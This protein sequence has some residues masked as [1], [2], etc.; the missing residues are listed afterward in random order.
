MIRLILLLS[1][2]IF[3]MNKTIFMLWLQG[4]ENAP[5][6]VTRCV[7]SWRYYNS[8]WNIILLDDNNLI[9][10]IKLDEYIDISKKQIEKCKIANI[11]RCILLCK[12]GGVWTDA[13]TFCNKPLNDWLPN[14]INE[15]F[16][17]FSK[18]TNGKM[19]SNWF[20]YAEKNNYII[21][22]WCNA[23]INFHVNNEMPYPYFIHHYLFGDLYNSD[24]KFKDIWDNVPKLS[25][26]GLGP[27]YLQEKG[28]FNQITDE[29]K[30]DIDNKITPLYKLTHKCNF[31]P[32]NKELNIYYL[33][34]TI[35]QFNIGYF[36][37]HTL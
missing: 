17:A 34:S 36:I 35:Q 30:E 12:Y 21:D 18:P 1:F 6:I 22:K 37:K 15:G 14:C 29:I 2:L 4:F 13:T 20:L 26:N 31:Q 16:F 11:I 28:M 7:E 27:H 23:T 32:Y 5:D 3:N 19:L 25:A 33:Y 24:D 9:D 8:D 10:Y